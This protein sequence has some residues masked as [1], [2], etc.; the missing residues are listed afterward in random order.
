MRRIALGLKPVV[1]TIH[2]FTP[3]YFGK[4]REVEFGIIHDA[5]PTYALAIHKAARVH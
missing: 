5:D 1:V 4:P 3:V 2:S